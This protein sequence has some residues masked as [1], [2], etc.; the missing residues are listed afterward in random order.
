MKLVGTAS[1]RS[2][3]GAKVRVQATIRGQTIRQMR[4]ITGNSGQDGGSGG[5]V[6]HFGLGDATKI[7]TIR[8][9]WPS[10]IVQELKDVAVNQQLEVVETQG[11]APESLVIGPC[12]RARMAPSTPTSIAPSRVRF[13]SWNLPRTSSDGPRFRWGRA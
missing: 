10:G 6:A 3:I 13:V 2:A 7:D 8:I 5:L 4:E 1:N 11:V 9:E 12:A